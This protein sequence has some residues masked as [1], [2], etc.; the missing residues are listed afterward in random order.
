MYLCAYMWGTIV[1]IYQFSSGSNVTYDDSINLRNILWLAPLPSESTKEWLA[2]GIWV[3]LYHEKKKDLVLNLLIF[4]PLLCY[5][6]I[7]L[8]T[9]WILMNSCPETFAT[10][11]C[12]CLQIY[13]DSCFWMCEHAHLPDWLVYLCTIF[14]QI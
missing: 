11:L 1:I 14:I 8:A 13:P 6:K 2:P 4:I 9:N 5:L 7:F 12:Y 3:S 10:Y